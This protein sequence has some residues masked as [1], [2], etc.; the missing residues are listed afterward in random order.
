MKELREG[1]AKLTEL[2]SQWQAKAGA[3]E[4]FAR[5]QALLSAH[6]D[7]S[8]KAFCDFAEKAMSSGGAQPV[9]K[10]AAKAEPSAR[11]DVVE[12]YL[13]ELQNVG[14]D[15]DAFSSVIKRL[16]KDKKARIQELSKIAT[17]Y[18]GTPISA[19]KKADALDAIRYRHRNISSAGGRNRD[20]GGIF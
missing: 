3:L 18:C 20:L 12:A 14:S 10:R 7:L 13:R 8:V 9:P 19:G 6:D 2:L 4:D 1:L 11:I 15:Q 5:L 16:D 17:E